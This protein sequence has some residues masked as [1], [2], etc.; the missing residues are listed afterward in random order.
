MSLTAA[1]GFRNEKQHPLERGF[2]A[3]AE[4]PQEGLS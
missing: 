2:N 1:S 4:P 3:G